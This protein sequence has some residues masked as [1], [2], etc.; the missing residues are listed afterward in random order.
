MTR[1][2]KRTL[3]CAF[4]G[5]LSLALVAGGHGLQ[6]KEVKN[7]LATMSEQQQVALA[8]SAAPAHIARGA[9]VMVPDKDGKLKRVKEGTNGFTCIPS[10]NK[11]DT[12]DP[13]CF[14]EAVG[15]WVE[16]LQNNAPAPTNKVPGIAY[17][18]RGGWHWEKDGKV[19]MKEEPGA[20]LVKEPPHWMMMWPFESKATMLPT[21]PNPS[22]AWI[23]FDGTPYAHL[24]IYQDPN[25]MK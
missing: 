1:H 16:A 17:M 14:D 22:G 24:M 4:C 5:S 9:A 13:M 7:P 25:K 10:V 8:L 18:A 20:K 19:L 6:A 15:Q 2:H 21:R 11:R 3:T 23:M 12:P